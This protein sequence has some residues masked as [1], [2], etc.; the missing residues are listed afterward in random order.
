MSIS[1]TRVKDIGPVAARALAQHGIDSVEA[2]A[3]LLPAQLGK[4]PGF[5][6]RRSERVIASA[7]SLLVTAES[8]GIGLGGKAAPL[9]PPGREVAATRK[10][11]GKGKGNKKKGRNKSGSRAA[12]AGKQSKKGSGRKNK[13]KDKKNKNKKNQD[14]GGKK[15]SGRKKDAKK[16]DRKKKGRKKK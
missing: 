15:L 10:G 3:S 8:A 12:R 9:E 2:L 16:R 7:K 11:K 5:G 4:V 1:L 13:D 6:P 14:K